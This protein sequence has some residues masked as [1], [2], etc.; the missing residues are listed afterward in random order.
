MNYLHYDKDNNIVGYSTMP[1]SNP[2][3]TCKEVS[4]EEYNIYTQKQ[5]EEFEL[6][7]LRQ[8]REQECFS[9]INRGKLW[10]DN[11]TEEQL[12]ELNTWYNAWLDVT[13]TKVMPERPSWI[14]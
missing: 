2:D 10:Y 7:N 9:I 5:N 12:I 4:K 6:Q 8:Q 11:L 14:K 1:V 13:E 3:F